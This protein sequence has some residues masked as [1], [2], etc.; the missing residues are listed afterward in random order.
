MVLTVELQ[1]RSRSESRE[2]IATR[3]DRRQPR[4]I[5]AGPGLLTTLRGVTSHREK[6]QP[7]VTPLFHLYPTS[8]SGTTTSCTRRVHRSRGV[9]V[10]SEPQGEF[11]TRIA[12]V[13]ALV[14]MG[15]VAYAQT[16]NTNF[17]PSAPFAMYR[18][19]T[20]TSGTPAPD[21][22][23]QDRILVAVTEQ[24]V[25]K[26]MTQT[27]VAPNLVV[28]THVVTH[29]QKKI[30]APGFGFG[31]WG[32]GWG[33]PGA[34]IDTYLQGTLIVDLYDAKTRKMVWRGVATDTV[35]DNTSKN[36]EHIDKAVGKMFETYPPAE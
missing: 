35:S 2:P 1:D 25:A 13:L 18:T 11:R 26:G 5:P 6:C 24:L 33:G 28:A 10:A 34:M 27:A 30:V 19:Y 17:D 12:S 32:W 3:G 29:E 23:I 36:T 31:P 21:P 4:R 8:E 9:Q 16:V 7:A 14:L 20:W 15:A 22:F